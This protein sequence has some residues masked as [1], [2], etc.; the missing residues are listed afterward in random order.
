MGDLSY[1][2]NHRDFTCKC[3]A[4]QGK[5]YKIHLG[6]VGA[7]E[8]ISSHFRKRAKIL[9]GYWCDDYLEKLKSE[10]RSY[11]NYGKAAHIMIDGIP[12]NELFKFVETIE[13]LFGIGFYPKEGFIH[14]DT[15]PKEKAAK[16]VKDGTNYLPLTQELRNKYNL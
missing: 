14:I 16:W 8:L 7:L 13:E 1:Y 15:R 6:L 10:K 12:L 5:E 9:S 11:H 2:F 4:C 3:S